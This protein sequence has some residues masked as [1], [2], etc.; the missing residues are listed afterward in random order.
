[1]PLAGDRTPRAFVRTPANEL[2]TRLLA[3]R[4]LHRLSLG[5]VGPSEVYVQGFAGPAGR[6]QVSS[7]GGENPVWARNGRELFYRAPGGHKMMAVDVTS[8]PALQVGRPR[9]LFERRF[10]EGVYDVHPDGRFLLIQVEEGRPPRELTL[11]LEWF[12][13]LAARVPVG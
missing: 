9:Q 12:A 4:P 1:M 6:I 8:G 7:Q 13:E 5:R 11:V 2:G 10:L 3:R